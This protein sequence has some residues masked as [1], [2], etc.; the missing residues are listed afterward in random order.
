MGEL[1]TSSS[2]PAKFVRRR[3]KSRLLMN[4]DLPSERRRRLVRAAAGFALAAAVTVLGWLVPSPV[5]AF[6]NRSFDLCASALERQPFA[7]PELAVGCQAPGCCSDCQQ[8]SALRW[9]VELGGDPLLAIEVQFS[10]LGG[11]QLAVE[12]ES[13]LLAGNLARINRGRSR[14]LGMQRQLP[15]G[16]PSAGRNESP[17]PR[18]R[19]AVASLKLRSTAV[20]FSSRMRE[21][22]AS[23]PFGTE[24]TRSELVVT[25]LLGDHIVAQSRAVVRFLHCPIQQ[26]R[27]DRINLDSNET[28]DDA[29][30]VLDTAREDG[31]SHHEV[32]RG[33]DILYVGNAESNADC[34]QRLW[35][36]SDG[37]APYF[38]ELP[39]GTPTESRT[40]PEPGSEEGDELA[41]LPAALSEADSLVAP[42]DEPKAT[43]EPLAPAH[44]D[45][46]NQGWSAAKGD[47]LRVNLG[48][49]L[50][51]VPVAVWVAARGDKAAD[52]ERRARLELA[53]A[54]R[55]LDRSHCGI[56]VQPRAL[57][58]P[59]LKREDA[60]LVAKF[61]RRSAGGDS[62]EA[63][64]ADLERAALWSPHG[65]NVYYVDAD[66]V[67][68]SCPR[69]NF[70][71]VGS[72]AQPETLL[73][74]LARSF[75]LGDVAE[76]DGPIDFDGDGEPDFGSNNLMGLSAERRD[77]L[78]EGQ[79]ARVWFDPRSATNALALR[80]GPVFLCAPSDQRPD[81]LEVGFD[82]VPN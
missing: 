82:A 49:G 10:G 36:F 23:V 48:G 64:I 11:A 73:N 20:D 4:L 15:G 1:A 28:R 9:E 24:L 29:V 69:Q 2:I 34:G 38:R 67:S 41:D 6:W 45:V 35:V 30:I 74:R 50:T 70:V 56:E 13:M 58:L 18:V 47:L 66:V 54:D 21:L 8:Q 57:V 39:E 59:A 63:I 71:V 78:S 51:A 25:Q 42:E 76:A 43:Q 31:C 3:S 37:D 16:P 61:V 80:Q 68:F 32:W 40:D 17:T 33:R 77:S 7:L 5:S 44:P 81:C 26:P 19:A 14:F 52:L 12:G 55:I 79:C 75:A 46:G 65:F 62:C 22:A 72:A 27:T 53:V 60:E